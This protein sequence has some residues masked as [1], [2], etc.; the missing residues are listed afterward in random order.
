M[1][2]PCQPQGARGVTR[3][4]SQGR[5]LST[6]RSP[7]PLE[8]SAW[9]PRRGRCAL[10]QL[11][12]VTLGLYITQIAACSS[13][14]AVRA[15]AAAALRWCRRGG[16][17]SDAGTCCSPEMGREGGCGHAGVA[18]GSDPRRGWG[19]GG[20]VCGTGFCSVCCRVAAVAHGGHGQACP[21]VRCSQGSWHSL[22]ECAGAWGAAGA[23]LAH[24][25]SV[26]NLVCPCGIQPDH[27][28]QPL[29][30]VPVPSRAR[31]GCAGTERPP[32]RRG[33]RHLGLS[34]G[35]CE[36]SA[37]ILCGLLEQASR[38]RCWRGER[39]GTAALP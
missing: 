34:G 12:A 15:A 7:C 27:S 29:P 24:G 11:D 30:S 22:A 26:S 25:S 38:C 39:A 19:P 36:M 16:L 31:R 35:S 10:E 9:T 5:G 23:S 13:L 3:G 6:C 21:P 14:A 37:N 4:D 8:P 28:L 32:R 18:T 20:D 2:V 33:A 17:E 1:V